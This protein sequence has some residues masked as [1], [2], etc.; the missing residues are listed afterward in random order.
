MTI[1]L[2]AAFNKQENY[3]SGGLTRRQQ[4]PAHLT[5]PRGPSGGTRFYGPGIGY[6]AAQLLTGRARV[7]LGNKTLWVTF[8]SSGQGGGSRT[9]AST[10]TAGGREWMGDTLGSASAPWVLFLAEALVLGL[11][12][13]ALGALRQ[14]ARVTGGPLA[15]ADLRILPDRDSAVRDAVL[16][17][18]DLAYYELK[19]KLERGEIVEGCFGVSALS[20]VTPATLRGLL[21]DSPPSRQ[22]ATSSPLARLR[23]LAR[24]GGAALLVGPPGTFKTETVKRLV[25]EVGAA[26]VKMRGTPGVEDRDFVG[27]ITPGVSG[28]EWVDGPLARAFMLAK[29]SLTVL[30]IDEVLRYH[31]E[32]LQLLVG[33]MDELSYADA[34]A[35]LRPPLARLGE[36]EQ[37]AALQKTLGGDQG[38]YY[39]L[40]LP[41]GE[42]IFCPRK[43]LLWALTT[44]M[45]EDHLQTAQNL[46]PALLSRIDLVIDLERPGVDVV[47]PIYEAVA[48]DP[49]LAQLAYELEDLTYAA[50]ADAEGLLVRPMDAR[51]TI[52]LLGEARACLEDGMSLHEALLEAAFVTAVPHCCPRD[53]RGVIEA[54]SREN[55]L[56]RV[57]EEVLG[58][59]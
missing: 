18:S 33:A 13:D 59:A 10:D 54:A 24:R 48:G 31:P 26:V 5:S 6:A 39:M 3:F 17:L 20:P 11:H 37:N 45:G 42:A 46:D 4:I 14:L 53:T 49:R 58:L 12:R 7:E 1:D 15:D 41:T 21:L 2:N 57:R 38:R 34:C 25:L 36:A 27:A 55:L 9:V 35:V 44:N 51:K 22:A 43:N 8:P 56:K 40:E 47:M 23:R 32:N 19:D 29:K 50:A 30:Q 28:P 16:Q 52:A